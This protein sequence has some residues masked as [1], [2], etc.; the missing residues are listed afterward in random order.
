MSRAKT[1]RGPAKTIGYRSDVG[2][3]RG[4]NEDSYLVRPDLGLYA[5]ADGMGGAGAGEVASALAVETLAEAIEAGL[6]LVAAAERANRAIVAAARDG[7]GANGMGTT[8]VALLLRD[9]AYQLAWVGDSRAY[10]VDHTLAQLSRDHSQVQE[11]VDA[12]VIGVGEARLHPQRNIITRVLGGPDGDR[13]EVETTHGRLESDQELLLCSDGLHGELENDEIAEL[14]TDRRKTAQSRV[15]AL[16][17][18]AL[19][20]G[21]RDN[22]TAVLVGTA[23]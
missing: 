10:L 3:R 6:D 22:V 21:G 14:V 16:I 23:P 7:R 18:A 1:A 15:D 12:G 5:V 4:N 19:E 8:L 2:R 9:K 20:R 17:S 11:L 13:A